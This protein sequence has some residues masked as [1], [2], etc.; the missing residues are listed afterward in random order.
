MLRCIYSNTIFFY[1][2]ILV[3]NLG[4]LVIRA[5]ANSEIGVGHVMRCLA[6]AQAW[7]DKGG[8]VRLVMAIPNEPVEQRYRNERLCC[9]IL[10]VEP[11]S[12]NDALR[13]RALAESTRASILLL[14]GYHFASDY[15]KVLHEGRFKVLVMD[16]FN[17]CSRFHADFLLNQNLH[18]S[19]DD[20]L[21]SAP[22]ITLLLG[23][24][25]T[26]L[27]R[28]FRNRARP[29]RNYRQPGSIK[30][31]LVTL[32]GSDAPNVTSNIVRAL[33]INNAF[34]PKIIVAVGNNNPHRCELELLE[35]EYSRK[36]DLRQNVTDM[37]SLLEEVDMAICAGGASCW[38][39]AYFGLPMF[40]VILAENQVQI[41]ESLHQSGACEN[42]GWYDQINW[43]VA[44]RTIVGRSLDGAYL[45][46]ISQRASGFVDGNGV[47]R[48][49]SALTLSLNL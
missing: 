3:S 32:G 23:N 21:Q 7:R 31:L 17:Y 27:R 13:T 26:M 22:N 40:V 9:E 39:M 35:K 5:D 41:A 47:D 37:G 15:Q 20:Y 46:E 42:F 6:L 49:I 48:I 38:E 8:S 43:E 4:T 19:P 1:L 12:E 36:V 25:Y 44:A 18:A 28:E 34:V 11:A 24:R 16:D 10:H 2:L 45:H 29:S 33:A 30:K 14:D